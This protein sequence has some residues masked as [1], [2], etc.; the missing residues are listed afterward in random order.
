MDKINI[1]YNKTNEEYI[2]LLEEKNKL[3]KDIERQKEHQ[4]KKKVS[5]REQG[6][7]VYLSGANEA[8]IKDQRK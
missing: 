5:E 3:K 4:D 1:G 6:F 7:N 2:E 8:R